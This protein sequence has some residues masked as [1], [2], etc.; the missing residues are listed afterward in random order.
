MMTI[1]ITHGQIKHKGYNIWKKRT[2]KT[3]VDIMQFQVIFW[4][5]D[6]TFRAGP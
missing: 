5:A 6:Q 3:G 2:E 4:E 1:I